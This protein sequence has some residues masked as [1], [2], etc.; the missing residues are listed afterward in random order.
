MSNTFSSGGL[1]LELMAEQV[2]LSG[3]SDRFSGFNT[4]LLLI[5]TPPADASLVTTRS[6]SLLMT[7]PFRRHSTFGTGTPIEKKYNFY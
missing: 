6:A 7:T 1:N 5:L 2:R 4:K 3:Q